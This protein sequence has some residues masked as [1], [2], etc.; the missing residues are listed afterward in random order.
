MKNN[1]RILINSLSVILIV[2]TQLTPA[3]HAQKNIKTNVYVWDFKTTDDGIK[4]FAEKFTDDFETEL[5]KL[6]K[7]TVLQRR[8]HSLVLVH[9]DMENKISNVKNLS[10]ETVNKLKTIRAE[11]VVFGELLEDEDSGIYEVIVFSEFKQWR[12]PKKRKYYHR[13]GFN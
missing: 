9:Q 7:Y 5:I 1:I 2:V 11:I 3:V 13:K 10:S 6:D 12:N 4:K 8:N